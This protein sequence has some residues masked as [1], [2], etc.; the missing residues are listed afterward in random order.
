MDT[1]P[2]KPDEGGFACHNYCVAFIDLLGQRE[3]MRGQGLVP[4][5]RTQLIAKFRDSIGGI[6][7][8]QHE[9][10]A[11]LKTLN[12]PNPNSPLKA[13]LPADQHE[14]WDAMMRTRVTTQRW[15]DGLVSFCCLGDQEIKCHVN[16]VFALI[17]LTGTIALLGLA[18][19]R[20]VRGAIEIAWGVELH[21][22]ELY[23][24]AV[25]RAYELESEVA[26]YPRIVVGPQTYH[27]LRMH[28]ESTDQD[29]FSQANRNLARICLDMLFQDEDGYLKVHYLG[30]AFA[31]WVNKSPDLYPL[32]RAFVVE[33]F[34]KHQRELNTKLAFRYAN[35]L[36][37]FLAHPAQAASNG[38]PEAA[39]THG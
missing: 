36:R 29:V 11:M 23:G 38:A 25:A 17:G 39:S 14:T 9:A 6:V 15:S 33:Q 4:S 1:T 8:L 27:F 18:Q 2:K 3:A 37:Y 22:G 31:R 19:K 30:G 28:G 21:E 35:L 26:Q 16:G 7:T 24:P 13:Q 10:E 32:A 5:D 20:P 34:E 12:A